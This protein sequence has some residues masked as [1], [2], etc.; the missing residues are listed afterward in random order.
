MASEQRARFLEVIRQEAV[1]MG[2]R[3]ER[4]LAG[5]PGEDPWLA[6]DVQACDLLD[7]LARGLQRAGFGVDVTACQERLW[8]QV[9]GYALQRLVVALGRR[10]TDEQRVERFGLRVTSSD[11]LGALD[12]LWPGTALDVATVRAWVVRAAG[13]DGDGHDAITRHGGE[14]WSGVEDGQGPGGGRRQ[15]YLRILLPRAPETPAPAAAAPAAA[16]AAAS[17][18]PSTSAPASGAAPDRVPSYDFSLLQGAGDAG[19][20]QDRPLSELSFTVFDTETTGLHA[21]EGHE[22]ISIGAVRIVNGRLLRQET[23][24]A[25]VDPRRSVPPESV[26]IHGITPEE[27]AGQPTLDVVLP[28]FAGFAEQTVLVGHHIAF[29]LQF[30]VPYRA[31]AGGLLRLPVL[32]TL[33]LSAV[34]NPEQDSH[35]IEHLARRLG[36]TVI[37]R[38]TALG[39]ALMTGELLL[40]LIPLLERRDVRTLGQAQE[41]SRLTAQG[42]WDD[43]L[44]TGA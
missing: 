27:L 15:A 28:A 17:W 42:R 25:L 2:E 44:Y 32:D 37:G 14:V 7:A 21:R 40:K 34:A 41:A 9:D 4:A 16:A 13:A 43:A 29:D 3:L 18:G 10:L 19:P 36:V 30:I 35:T 26:A 39:D 33:L 12:L 38:H 23:F 24:D 22:I 11:R 1:G 6:T 20:W 5:A 8:L 31:H